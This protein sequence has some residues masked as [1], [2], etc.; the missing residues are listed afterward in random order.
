MQYFEIA[1]IVQSIERLQNIS[2]NWLLPSFVLAANGVGSNALV[3]ISSR[4]GTDQFLDKYFNADRIGVAPY[5]T[6]NNL[7][8][9]RMKGMPDWVRGPFAGDHVI[10]QDTKLWANLL[11][12]RGYRDMRKEGLLDGDKGIARLT[13]G[14]Q[15]RFEQEIP[16][17]F[18]FEDLLVW[19]FAFEGF[20]DGIGSWRE[21]Y[22]YLLQDHFGLQTLPP[23][24]LGRFRVADPAVPWPPL[25][26]TRP[27]NEVY[28]HELAPRLQNSLNEAQVEPA[29]ALDPSDLPPLQADDPVLAQVQGAIA[30]GAA[31]SFLLAGPPGTGKTRYARQLAVALAGSGGTANTLFLQFHPALGYDDFIEG[32]RPE[33]DASGQGVQYDLKPRLFMK[34]V[35]E[36][37]KA[38]DNN[39][40]VVIDELNRGDVARIFGEVL[41]YL[42]PDYREKR[43][44]L[45]FSG[46][47]ASLPKNLIILA[48]ANPF[49]RSVTDLDDALLRRFWVIEMLPDK[50]V[51]EKHLAD[52]LV[53]Q[54][55]INRTLRLFE[56]MDANLPTG[57][58]HTSLLGVRSI[59]DL[60]SIWIGRLRL[61]LRRTLVADRAT[62]DSVSTSIEALWGAREAAA[63]EAAAAQGQA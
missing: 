53:E 51:L 15:A 31:Y 41:T 35:A 58:G 59:E 63:E 34:F 26:D 30:A 61:M 37:N 28:L 50:A 42:E 54:S 18:R 47:M 4:L 22:D 33:K 60:I 8:R 27:D 5:K 39:F 56:I 38:K 55:V 9:P 14:F 12:S 49:D 10:R 43:F 23:E 57:F 19:L 36:A 32:F 48:T 52:A 3:D 2:P 29:D 13:S 25:L 45:S 7:L 16:A 20:P 17:D 6:G 40:V 24:Y 44:T 21:L 46:D 11:S 62:F 1:T